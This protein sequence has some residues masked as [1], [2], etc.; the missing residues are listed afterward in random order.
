M[1]N[2]VKQTVHRSFKGLYTN[3][4]DPPEGSL[5]SASNMVLNKTLGALEVCDGYT[6]KFPNDMPVND[7]TTL[8]KAVF[9]IIPEN[10]HHFFVSAQGGK[11]IQVLIASQTQNHFTDAIVQSTQQAVWI[12]PYWDGATWVDKWRELTETLFCEIVALPGNPDDTKIYIDDGV[13]FNFAGLDP[14]GKVFND[15][16]F[17][18]WTC[19]YGDYN[20]SENF[21]LIFGCGFDGNNYYI[22]I[23]PDRAKH[24]TGDYPSRI[25][26][27][28]LI[29]QRNFLFKPMPAGAINSFLYN[30]L[31]EMRLTTGNNQS[32]VQL[33]AG[34]RSKAFTAD[35]DPA[36][37][38]NSIILAP[39][40]FDVWSSG[41]RVTGQLFQELGGTIP[42]SPAVG[43]TAY[44]KYNIVTDDGQQGS[45]FDVVDETDGTTT[46]F[47]L[48][49]GGFGGTAGGYIALAVRLSYGA[50]PKRAAKVNLWESSD[51]K[52]YHLMDTIDIINTTHSDWVSETVTIG[53]VKHFQQ[54]YYP[55]SGALYPGY[56]FTQTLLD[57]AAIG[58]LPDAWL[59]RDPRDTGVAQYKH[60]LI[61]DRTAFVSGV[62]LNGVLYPNHVVYSSFSGEGV[63][64]YDAFPDDLTFPL[65][66]QQSF[67]DLENNDGDEVVACGALPNGTI[68]ALKKRAII[69]ILPNASGGYDAIPV[70]QGYGLAAMRTLA[71]F[72]Y[73]LYWLDYSGAVCRYSV[74]G[75]EVLNH[76]LRQ[77]TLELSDALKESAIGIFDR[78]NRQYRLFLA[79]KEYT[80]DLDDGE[81]M[82]QNVPDLPSRYNYDD[83]NHTVESLAGGVI[84]RLGVEGELFSGAPINFHAEMNREVNNDNVLEDVNVLHVYCDYVSDVD[85]TL[86]VFKGRG[87]T[88]LGAP[89][90]LPHT[91]QEFRKRL[92]L[93]VRCNAYRLRIEGVKTVAG[94]NAIIYRLGAI[95]QYLEA[96]GA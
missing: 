82:I 30:V 31:S 20:D 90:V 12:R 40:G 1:P 17:K 50:A 73:A 33:M 61:I 3:V 7:F 58:E 45:L 43:T 53:T 26:G 80:F 39:A 5:L 47:T 85:L 24:K 41:L 81:W 77:E 96:G 63:S 60:A 71:R 49:A 21:D 28:Q 56:R 69:E 93:S 22:Q 55:N 8:A 18:G 84:E 64:E 65:V 46:L 51:G 91:D 89:Y 32:D 35:T 57:A 68:L 83:Q 9:N 95:T 59:G 34:Y 74:N 15:T 76:Q 16:Y 42:D 29:L 2:R 6:Q 4:A 78:D 37:I 92:P 44:F 62:R 94:Q 88:V 25:V 67:I 13:K 10:I 87:N 14:Q 75:I 23:S 54:R 70:S 52:T 79:G 48:P 27:T 36:R 38:L 66:G 11:D 72:D 86:T 19:I